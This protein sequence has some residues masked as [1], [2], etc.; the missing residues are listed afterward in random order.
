MAKAFGLLA[1]GLPV[2]GEL[3]RWNGGADG[4]VRG[5]ETAK[6]GH[7]A[8]AGKPRLA[9]ASKLNAVAMRFFVSE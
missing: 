5:M 7:D 6:F 1:P 4:D 2:F 9:A 8:L 3:R